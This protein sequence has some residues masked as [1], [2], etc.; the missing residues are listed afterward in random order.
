MAIRAGAI[1][2]GRMRFGSGEYLHHAGVA[3][4][5]ER[6]ISGDEQFFVIAAMHGVAGCALAL[7]EGLVHAGSQ[8]VIGERVM[9]IHAEMVLRLCEEICR[10][11]SVRIVAT[12]AG[13]RFHGGVRDGLVHRLRDVVMAGQTEFTGSSFQETLFDVAVSLVAMDASFHGGLMRVREF[14]LGK[15]SRV[16]F[17]AD[18]HV[19]LLDQRELL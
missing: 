1:H 4:F 16:A 18:L 6:V 5:A 2:E 3:G 14:G 9:A 17:T 13:F 10:V 19:A 11:G 7:K 12:P 15:F 8:E